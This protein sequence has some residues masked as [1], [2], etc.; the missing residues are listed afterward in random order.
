MASAAQQTFHRFMAMKTGPAAKRRV[1]N[2]HAG[3]TLPPVGFADRT[4]RERPESAS[5]IAIILGVSPLCLSRQAP[6]SPVEM[7]ALG[8]VTGGHTPGCLR[9]VESSRKNRYR[10]CS[11]KQTHRLCRTNETLCPSRTMSKMSYFAIES[12]LPMRY[13]SGSPHGLK[14][15]GL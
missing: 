12:L 14:C 11:R 10:A 13:V 2:N 9:S 6:S 7:T 1:F 3:H 15:F 4:W 5:A 8:C